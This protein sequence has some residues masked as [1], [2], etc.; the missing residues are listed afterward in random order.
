MTQNRACLVGG[1]SGPGHRDMGSAV[2]VT[3]SFRGPQS[4]QFPLEGEEGLSAG[5][6]E[7]GS[8]GGKGSRCPGRALPS[9]PA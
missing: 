3:V 5:P 7:R 1:L 2:T 8:W 4:R 9:G 6:L